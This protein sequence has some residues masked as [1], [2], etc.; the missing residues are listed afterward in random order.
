M[1]KS[2][3]WGARNTETFFLVAEEDT[4]RIGEK[5]T[6]TGGIG[7]AEGGSRLVLRGPREQVQQGLALIESIQGEPPFVE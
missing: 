2:S 5:G 6:A 3:S 4:I 1:N 7:G